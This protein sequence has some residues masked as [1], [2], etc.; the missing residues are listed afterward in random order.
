[1]TTSLT[2]L[3]LPTGVVNDLGSWGVVGRVFTFFSPF[4]A[5]KDIS[6]PTCFKIP[7]FHPCLRLFASIQTPLLLFFRF[8]LLVYDD[9]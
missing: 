1:L 6:Q 7:S 9:S 8:Y 4:V 5:R 3:D 2:Y